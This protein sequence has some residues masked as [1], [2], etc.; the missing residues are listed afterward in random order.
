M[1]PHRHQ[2]QPVLMGV[3]EGVEKSE[4]ENGST[5]KGEVLDEGNYGCGVHGKRKERPMVFDFIFPS[6]QDI[7]SWDT[8][9]A[10]SVKKCPKPRFVM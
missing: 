8:T 1:L 2:P 9:G 6:N 7:L 3:G 5:E 10:V 4:N